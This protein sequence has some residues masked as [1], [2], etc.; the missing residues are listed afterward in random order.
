MSIGKQEPFYLVDGSGLIFRAYYGIR[1]PMTAKDGTPTN[2]VFGFVRLLSNLVR[3]QNAKRMLVVFDAKGP[4]FRNDIFPE[5]KAN[6]SAPP[7]DLV[8]Q[9]ALCREATKNLGIGYSVVEGVEA[10]D[11][12]GTLAKRWAQL[13]EEHRVV[14]VTAD[15]DMCQLVTPQVTLWDGKEK[16]TDSEG[17]IEKFGVPPNQIAQIIFRASLAL[18]Q[19]PPPP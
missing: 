8:P 18:V 17:V 10:D 1:A 19:K 3:D 16:Y 11:V 12:I 5:Y 4:T 14:I 13:D 2:A 9:F 7:D 15:K 6:R